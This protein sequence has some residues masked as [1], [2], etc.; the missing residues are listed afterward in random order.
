M[1]PIPGNWV[2]IRHAVVYNARV[3][4]VF[5]LGIEC[6]DCISLER[7]S[8]MIFQCCHGSLRIIMINVLICREIDIMWITYSVDIQFLH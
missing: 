5:G 1:H 2:A 6:R 4:H 8:F 7:L 3:A